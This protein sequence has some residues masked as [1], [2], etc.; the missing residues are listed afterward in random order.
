MGDDPAEHKVQVRRI[1]SLINFAPERVVLHLREQAKK[2]HRLLGCLVVRA[3]GRLAREADKGKL[4]HRACRPSVGLMLSEPRLHPCVV[5]MARP[6]KGEQDIHIEQMAFHSPSS[7]KS[8][9]TRWLVMGGESAGTSKVGNVDRDAGRFRV[10][11]VPPELD[12]SPRAAQSEITAPT[13]R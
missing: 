4:R 10:A 6:R 7:L 1:E 12:C 2:C 9:F 3:E 5:D 8:C 11:P 13:L